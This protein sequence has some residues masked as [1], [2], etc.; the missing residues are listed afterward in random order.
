MLLGLAALTRS[1]VW[2]FPLVL[3][4]VVGLLAPVATSRKVTCAL[5]LVVAH[6]A[7][8]APWAIRNTRLQGVPVIVDTMGG[9]NLRMGNYEFTPHDRIWDAVA[10][11]GERSW[12]V[13][14]PPAPPG[15][16]EWNE[17]WK[18]R[19]AR[20]QAVAFMRAHPALTL[21]R[22]GIKFADFWALD[23]DFAAGIQQ[24]LFHPPAWAAVISVV[25]LTVAFPLVLGLAILGATLVPPAEWRAHVVLLLVIFFVTAMHTLVFGHPRYRLPLTPVLA[26]YAGGALAHRAW[27]R[28]REGWRIGLLPAALAVLL[29]CMWTTQFVARDWPFVRRLLGGE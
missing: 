26:V 14:L 29:A 27:H 28:L 7:V 2:P 25:S 16:G 13:G 22:M 12:I 23:R 20:D 3:A 1:V 18:E 11:R 15:G 21:W 19:W 10:Q 24:G 8:I 9:M 6:A 4:P 17:G 5:L